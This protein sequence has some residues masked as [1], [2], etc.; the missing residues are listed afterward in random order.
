MG[1]ERG[2][3]IDLASK[4]VTL[5]A[6]EVRRTR[7]Y[8]VESVLLGVYSDIQACDDVLAES[9]P[10]LPQVFPGKLQVSNLQTYSKY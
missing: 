10:S 1:W 2:D 3:Q 9:A 4:L 5:C 7:E 6:K 8:H